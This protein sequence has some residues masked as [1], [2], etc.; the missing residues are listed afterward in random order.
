MMMHARAWGVQSHPLH[1]TPQEVDGDVHTHAHPLPTKRSRTANQF[2][3]PCVGDW[4]KSAKIVDLTLHGMAVF[5]P[6]AWAERWVVGLLHKRLQRPSREQEKQGN[7]S[8]DRL[9]GGQGQVGSW[10]ANSTGQRVHVYKGSLWVG[11]VRA[12]KRGV[13]DEKKSS[14][15]EPAHSSWL[16]R[17]QWCRFPKLDSSRTWHVLTSTNQIVQIGIQSFVVVVVVIPY[18]VDVGP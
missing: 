5:L 10:S 9:Q 17:H 8:A 4:G 1:G 11:L 7:L 15:I 14:S 16:P 13:Q 18:V 6:F 3:E 2:P 12:L